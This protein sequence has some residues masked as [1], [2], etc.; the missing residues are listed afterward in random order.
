[1]LLVLM[2][3]I[4]RGAVVPCAVGVVCVG[5]VAWQLGIMCCCHVAYSRWQLGIMC[6]CHV[7]YSRWVCGLAP[8]DH[9]LLSCGIS[10][11]AVMEAAGHAAAIWCT[12][13]LQVAL[14]LVASFWFTVGL[15]HK[16]RFCVIPSPLQVACCST[17][18]RRPG[19][20]PPT[21]SCLC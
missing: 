8:E 4:A 10:P 20:S 12:S 21:C 6:C 9:V 19:S 3:V 7:A 5:Y 18:T 14:H 2:C 1:V 17:W 15:Y 11:L 16:L 13:L